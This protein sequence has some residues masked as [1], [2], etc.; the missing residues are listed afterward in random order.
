MGEK[1]KKDEKSVSGRKL[2]RPSRFGIKENGFDEILNLTRTH[3][4]RI[5]KVFQS[6]CSEKGGMFE[7]RRK[8]FF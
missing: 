1:R 6:S 5:V 7:N 8:Y 2:T 3:C 4:L